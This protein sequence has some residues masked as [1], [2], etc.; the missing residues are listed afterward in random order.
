MLLVIIVTEQS[1]MVFG[2]RSIQAYGWGVVQSKVSDLSISANVPNWY[3]AASP[4]LSKCLREAID[5][6]IIASIREL[7]QLIVNKLKVRLVT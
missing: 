1:P 7:P 3:A 5:Q 4:H 6:V 2:L